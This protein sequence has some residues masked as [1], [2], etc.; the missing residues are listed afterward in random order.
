MTEP[1]HSADYVPTLNDDLDALAAHQ[2]ER[3]A[4]RSICAQCG[5]QRHYHV[6]EGCRACL[7]CVQF[8]GGDS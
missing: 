6:A 4:A 3:T 2:S 5:Y 8:E 7:P 1:T